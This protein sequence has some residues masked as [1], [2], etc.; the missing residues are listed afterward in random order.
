MSVLQYDLLVIDL[1]G[2]L[3]RRDGSVSARNVEAVQQ[4][5]DAG[6]EVIVATGRALVE[7]QRALK[8][9]AHEGLMIAAGGSMLCCVKSGRTLA[10]RVMP[11]Q[12]VRDAT[13][14][15]L[16][17]GHKVLILKD[18]NAAGYDYLAVGQGELDP[19]SRWWFEQLP[20]TVRFA[21]ELAE[22]AHPH[23]TVRA[24]VVA[25][26][27]E[28]GPIAQDLKEKLGEQVFLQ[29]W[30][31]VTS[32]EAI[33]SQTHLLEVFNP[34]VNKWT[35]IQSH[36]AGSG[37]DMARVVTIGDGLNDVEMLRGAGLGVAMGNADPRAAAVADRSAGDHENDGVAEVI[38][39]ILNG[40]C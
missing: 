22:D 9:I 34:N 13:D 27:S 17:H 1:D 26:G 21:E 37:I 36:C 5:R 8:A 6:V 25:S 11:E 10:R 19:A 12:V 28:L 4:A 38:E 33:G 30:P 23:D 2:T 18:S 3:L 16:G 15:L 24:A 32:S 39:L 29:H 20:V 40:G 31:A 7:S 14:A 35:M